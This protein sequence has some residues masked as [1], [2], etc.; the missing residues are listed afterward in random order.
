M[1]GGA[2][3]D[4]FNAGSGNGADAY[5]GDA[6]IDLVSYALTDEG[7]HVDLANGIGQGGAAQDDT[8]YNIEK[9]NGS[10]QDDT[11]IGDA[12]DNVLVGYGG[13]DILVGGLGNDVLWGATGADTFA[14]G[15]TRDEEADTIF[16]FTAGVDK[17]DFTG[18]TAW[19]GFNDLDSPGNRYWEQ[20]GE[21]TVIHYYEHTIT[22]VGIDKDTLSS[23][24]FLF[25]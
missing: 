12:N 6:G 11:I 23:D 9:V 8:Y 21:D 25:A 24:D 15:D 16:D 1:Y 10:T 3:N 13:D 7:V 17:I 4:F 19:T 14:F 5:H 2:G 18:A 20:V 22:L